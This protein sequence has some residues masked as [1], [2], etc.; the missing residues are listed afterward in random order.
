MDYSTKPSTLVPTRTFA[1]ATRLVASGCAL[2]LA[3]GASIAHAG[4]VGVSGVA[5]GDGSEELF[6]TNLLR[7]YQVVLTIIDTLLFFFVPGWHI[8][9]TGNTAAIHLSTKCQT[10][11]TGTSK[12]S[13]LVCSHKLKVSWTSCRVWPLLVDPWLQLFDENT[14]SFQ[15]KIADELGLESSRWFTL[16]DDVRTNDWY[17]V[18]WFG[19][20]AA[21]TNCPWIRTIIYTQFLVDK[22]LETLMECK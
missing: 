16:D 18:G 17:W 15:Q 7:F 11:T 1:S 9:A 22:T 8:E 12:G 10:T 13:C 4:M 14:A 6:G 3:L 19:F 21:E 20:T 2:L 5:T